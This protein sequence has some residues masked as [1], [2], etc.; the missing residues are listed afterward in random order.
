MSKYSYKLPC[1]Q[2]DVD[3][4]YCCCNS[5]Y[6]SLFVSSYIFKC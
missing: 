1:L 4:V 6:I 3:M 2:I 5:L